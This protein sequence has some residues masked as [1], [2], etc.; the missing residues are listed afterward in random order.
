[1]AMDAPECWLRKC[2]H[3]QGVKQFGDRS[4]IEAGERY[5]CKAL[6]KGIPD[7]IADGPNKHTKVHPKQK[8]KIVYERKEN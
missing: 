6:P 8:N 5:V 3:Y 4:E 1:M 7:E 2:K